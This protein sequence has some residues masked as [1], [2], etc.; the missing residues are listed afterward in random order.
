[1]IALNPNF[2]L[3][4][5]LPGLNSLCFF[6]LLAADP[7]SLLDKKLSSTKK[8]REQAEAALLESGSTVHCAEQKLPANQH[9][10]KS[11]Y[12]PA[13]LVRAILDK[14]LTLDSPPSLKNILTAWV[15]A[16]AYRVQLSRR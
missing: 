10:L 9:R 11:S 1:L 6:A 7:L 12:F 14:L 3:H 16:M 5:F 2:L 4:H 13:S 8:E 15:F